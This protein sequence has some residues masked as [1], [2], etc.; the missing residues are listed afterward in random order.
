MFRIYEPLEL[1]KRT[2]FNHAHNDFLEILLDGG[3][4]ALLLLLGSLGWYIWASIRAWRADPVYYGLGR[5]GSGMILLILVASVFD[6]P[7]RTPIFMAIIVIAAI[8]L[9]QSASR[10]A[11]RR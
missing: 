10:I 8:W 11:L 2:Y 4:P 9:G 1:L 3:L 6:Y 5:L 7:A